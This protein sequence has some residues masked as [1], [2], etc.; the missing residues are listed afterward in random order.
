MRRTPWVSGTSGLRGPQDLVAQA[1]RSLADDAMATAEGLV[2]IE[3][4]EPLVT[5]LLV[6]GLAAGLRA[7]LR[8]WLE[9]RLAPWSSGALAG[10]L[11]RS[12]SRKEAP[13]YV[14]LCQGLKESDVARVARAGCLTPEALI[15]AL[16]LTD[17]KCCG[18]CAREIETFLRLATATGSPAILQPTE[19]A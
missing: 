11:R 19:T 18:R 13:S 2:L 5:V 16:K 1:E 15:A 9:Q 8:G 12:G 17:P 6:F 10:R 3:A 14:C 4:P 7:R